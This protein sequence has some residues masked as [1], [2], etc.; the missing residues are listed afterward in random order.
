MTPKD[1]THALL[2]G[3][4][5]TEVFSEALKMAQRGQVVRAD[6]D[7]ATSEATGG[8]MLPNGWEMKTGFSLQDRKSVV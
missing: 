3:W 6:W 7:G 2:S 4:G 5:G 8:V 1:F